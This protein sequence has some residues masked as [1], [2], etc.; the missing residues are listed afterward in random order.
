MKTIRILKRRLER[1]KSLLSEY[2][3]IEMMALSHLSLSE[4]EGETFISKA[5]RLI[6]DYRYDHECNPFITLLREYID[7]SKSSTRTIK[8][9]DNKHERILTFYAGQKIGYIEGMIEAIETTLELL[10]DEI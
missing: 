9:F 6:K 4:K 1:Y 8:K 2:K 7:S 10:E 5:E 3:D